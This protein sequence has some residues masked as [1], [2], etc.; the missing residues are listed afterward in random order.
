ML[1]FIASGIGTLILQNMLMK[2]SSRDGN[3]PYIRSFTVFFSFL[4][5]EISFH[6]V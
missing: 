4:T 1:L 3:D 6:R 5:A 2:N